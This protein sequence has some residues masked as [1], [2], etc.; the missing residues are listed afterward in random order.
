MESMDM[1]DW[2]SGSV[3]AGNYGM[4][5]GSMCENSG[6]PGGESMMVDEDY[7][8]LMTDTLFSTISSNQPM[9]FPDPREIGNFLINMSNAR[10]KIFVRIQEIL[11]LKYYFLSSYAHISEESRM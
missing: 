9:Y 5:T 10:L 8:E 7:M 3:I 11:T 4:G 6:A 2:D 1:L